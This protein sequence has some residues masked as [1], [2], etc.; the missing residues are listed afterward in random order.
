MK[1]GGM[2]ED[3]L[4]VLLDN[5]LITDYSEDALDKFTFK[6]GKIQQGVPYELGGYTFL[7]SRDGSRGWK[8][9]AKNNGETV[10]IQIF[11]D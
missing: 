3:A 6:S 11:T 9:T 4:K 5:K 1:G 8:L 10:T 2:K 7:K